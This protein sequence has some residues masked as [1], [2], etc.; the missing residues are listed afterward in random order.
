MDPRM[1][2]LAML[3]SPTEASAAGSES[4]ETIM[5]LDEDLFRS[6]NRR[7]MEEELSRNDIMVGFILLYDVVGVS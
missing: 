1:P 5:S 3:P 7:R 4:L 6:E 2:S